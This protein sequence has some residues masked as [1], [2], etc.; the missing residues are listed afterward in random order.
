[1]AR[2]KNELRTGQTQQQLSEL[3]LMVVESQLV[4]NLDFDDNINE[5]TNRKERRKFF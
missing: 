3:S 5:F 2:I 1:M 4:R